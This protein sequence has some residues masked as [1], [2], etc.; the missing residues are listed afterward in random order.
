MWS[1]ARFGVFQSTHF[2]TNAALK[3]PQVV[4]VHDLFHEC[5]PDCFPEYQVPSFCQRRRSCI[6]AADF[7]VCDS[8]STLEDLNRIFTDLTS[9]R[10]TVWL[11]VDTQFRRLDSS[12]RP[13]E[14]WKG[15]S[16]PFI[17]YVGTRYPYKNF[18]GLLAGFASWNRRHAFQLLV[19]GANASPIE[20]ALIRAFGLQDAIVFASATDEELVVAYNR[21][22][23]L[24]VPS[25]SEGFGL[26]V[27]EAMACGTPVVAS[28]GG[29]LEEVGAGI[30]VHFDF[31]MPQQL[32]G[33]LEEA[34]SIPRSSER[35]SDGIDIA[36]KR[37]W[38]DVADDYVGI[39]REVLN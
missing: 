3:I 30:A 39:Y 4:T 25:L 20:N 32:A 21:A 19:L 16:K 22:S 11:A 29:S 24:V 1:M 8:D 12:D 31:G 37:T 33:A 17:L 7:L 38:D 26:P 36:T 10:K 6:N 2:T 13:S 35:F 5:L 18:T 15:I 34:I 27:W 28:R 9:P 14:Y 23:A